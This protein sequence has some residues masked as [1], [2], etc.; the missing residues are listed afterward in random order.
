MGGDVKPE[1]KA[2]LLEVDGVAGKPEAKA[3][4]DKADKAGKDGPTGAL[5]IEEPTG[6]EAAIGTDG[7]EENKEDNHEKK[8]GKAETT[9]QDK[10]LET[11]D[12]PKVS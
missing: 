6:A 4:S 3:A 8:G 11:P 7:E 5:Q 12:E 1:P 9:A 10:P 2:P